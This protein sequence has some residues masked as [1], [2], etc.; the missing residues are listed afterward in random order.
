MRDIDLVVDHEQLNAVLAQSIFGRPFDSARYGLFITVSTD[1]CDAQLARHIDEARDGVAATNDQ[2]APT[3]GQARLQILE[4]LDDEAELGVADT[5]RL[6]RGVEH[7]HEGH[8]CTRL[9]RGRD[10][11]R[12]IKPQIAAKPDE[13]RG[14]HHPHLRNRVG[15][16]LLGAEAKQGASERIGVERTQ[17]VE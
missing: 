3:L 11:V 6:H 17:I 14:R 12:I 16:G 7:V 9:E 15:A 13:D 10:R 1:A 8:R 5:A 2:A 4:P